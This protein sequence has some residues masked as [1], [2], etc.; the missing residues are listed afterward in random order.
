MCVNLLDDYSL[1]KRP[2][3]PKR[4]VIDGWFCPLLWDPLQIS[5]CHDKVRSHLFNPSCL[6]FLLD[7]LGPSKSQQHEGSIELDL[8]PI[9]NDIRYFFIFVFFITKRGLNCFLTFIH[10][11]VDISHSPT[12]LIIRSKDSHRVAIHLKTAFNK[13]VFTVARSHNY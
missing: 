7:K 2:L 8:P 3:A 5:Q 1:P 11:F 10:H 6:G 4:V 9:V 13:K 12:S